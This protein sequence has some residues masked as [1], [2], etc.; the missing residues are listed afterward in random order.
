MQTKLTLRMDEELIRIAKDFARSSGK[1]LS[2][3]VADYFALLGRENQDGE[4]SH[5]VRSLKGSLRGADT[6]AY[7]RYLEDK[8]L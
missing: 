8:H 7:Q 3:I 2:R 4:M 5:V 6:E 1:S